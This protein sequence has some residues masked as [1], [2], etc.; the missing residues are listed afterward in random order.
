MYAVHE[1]HSSADFIG[2]IVMR[3]VSSSSMEIP[4]DFLPP[5]SLSVPVIEI[6]YQFLPAFWNR[7]FATESLNAMFEAFRHGPWEGVYVTA[8]VSEGNVASL[9]VAEKAG[10][11][12]L[13]EWVQDG[14]VYIAEK[15]R[16]EIKLVGWGRFFEN[17]TV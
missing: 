15:W 12:C 1:L 6:G 10:M 4:L 13:G 16:E 5:S 8:I 7:G 3:T 9:R 2:L 14:R 11:E 17:D